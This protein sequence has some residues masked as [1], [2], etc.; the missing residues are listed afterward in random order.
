MRSIPTSSST[1]AHFPSSP[2]SSFP[3]LFTARQEGHP[4]SG[5]AGRA[6]QAG[7]RGAFQIRKREREKRREIRDGWKSARVGGSPLPPPLTLAAKEREGL[8]PAALCLSRHWHCAHK[9]LLDE[10][11]RSFCPRPGVPT[12]ACHNSNLILTLP[13]ILS[14]FFFHHSQPVKTL[15]NPQKV[16]VRVW[17]KRGARKARA[18]PRT[19]HSLL[20]TRSLTTTS[21]FHSLIGPRLRPRRRRPDHPGR[22]RRPVRR[23]WLPDRRRRPVKREGGGV[24]RNNRA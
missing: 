24:K 5:Q 19:S 12:R 7:V 2:L 3:F 17:R 22:Q 15:Y 4:A 13:T 21:F 1:H 16:S 11:R 18:A 20:P 9:L 8:C 10:E 6:R 23:R 14:F